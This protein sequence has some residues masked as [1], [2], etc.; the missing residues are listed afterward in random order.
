VLAAGCD[1][2]VTPGQELLGSWGLIGTTGD[3]WTFAE[4]LTYVRTGSW[5]ETGA[6]AVEDS[7]LELRPN[8]GQEAT[9]FDFSSTRD[10]WLAFAQFAVGETSGRTGT[11]RGF[12]ASLDADTTRTVTTTLAADGT[13][14]LIHDLTGPDGA[15]RAEGD[16]TWFDSGAGDNSFMVVARLTQADGSVSDLDYRLWHL[17]DA[18]GTY[19]Y[20]RIDF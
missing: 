19:A 6:F 3:Q 7:R 13:V 1:Q 17:G 14:H 11:Y 15:T 16:G 4:D 2:Q 20:E 10:H 8:D 12:R 5:P 18:I 9:A